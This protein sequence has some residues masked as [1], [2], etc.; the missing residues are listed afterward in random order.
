VSADISITSNRIA[1]A[2]I[3]YY[4]EGVIA[5]KTKPGWLTRLLDA[6]WPF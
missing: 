2:H 4:G 5:D 3:A 6:L 1:D